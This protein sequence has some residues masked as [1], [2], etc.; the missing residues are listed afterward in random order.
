MSEIPSDLRYTKTH[1]WVRDEGDG[2]FTTGITD[3]AQSLLGDLVF[4]EL[5]E[6]G[7]TKSQG[8][9]CAVV[10]SVK[11]ASDVYVPL[12][13]TIEEVN[14]ALAD[15]PDLVNTEPYEGG[16]LYKIRISDKKQLDDLLSAQE[17]EEVVEEAAA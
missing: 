10:E 11:A 6:V 15:S 1:E 8:D 2:L 13:G 17:Y 14:T 3:T 5:P 7:D 12:D 4:V 9:D 16:W